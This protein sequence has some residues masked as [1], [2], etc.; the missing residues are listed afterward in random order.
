[1]LK[2]MIQCVHSWWLLNHQMQNTEDTYEKN[3][4]ECFDNYCDFTSFHNKC[5][6][7][8]ISS[9]S[10]SRCFDAFGYFTPCAA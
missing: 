6:C 7:G 10:F 8:K 5:F 2:S 1:M 9:Y 4:N 3:F